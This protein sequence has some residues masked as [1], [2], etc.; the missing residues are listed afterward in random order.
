MMKT[1]RV[2]LSH[3]HTLS[4]TRRIEEKRRGEKRERER[5]IDRERERIIWYD[6]GFNLLTSSNKT[7]PPEYL[8]GN[9]LK[10]ALDRI[11]A[12]IAIEIVPV[13]F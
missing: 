9:V 1:A 6:G 13:R 12:K 11:V 10:R 3:S 4:K 7:R 8:E 2:S 5:E